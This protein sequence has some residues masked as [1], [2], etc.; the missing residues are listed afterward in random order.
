MRDAGDLDQAETVRMTG[1]ADVIDVRKEGSRITLRVL[2]QMEG[3]HSLI[4]GR[5]ARADVR[6][7]RKVRSEVL[8]MLNLRGLLGNIQGKMWSKQ[9]VIEVQSLE[10]RPGWRHK[11]VSHQHVDVI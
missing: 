11:L 3:C 4:W 8:A 2:K 9:F 5:L 7:G 6:E 1:F 10:K